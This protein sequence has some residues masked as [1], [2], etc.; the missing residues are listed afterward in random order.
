MKRWLCE[1]GPLAARYT[2]YD[3]FFVYWRGGAD[4]V[5]TYVSGDM[6]GGH[7]VAVVGYD[8]AQSC[9]IC[10]NSWGPTQ[11]N[12]GC[13]RIGYGECGIDSRMYLIEDIYEVHTR[14][15]LPYNPRR[16]RI[17]D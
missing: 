2:V 12:D 10:K 7:V 16:L 14:D 8:D 1:E 6:A 17:V 4:G 13:F 9:W 3:D 5:Y 11:G 15:G